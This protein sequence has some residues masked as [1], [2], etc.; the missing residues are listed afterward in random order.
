MFY[1][2][3]Y[4]ETDVFQ[5]HDLL[6]LFFGLTVAFLL[7]LSDDAYDT[8]PLIK[9]SCQILCGVILVSTGSG[10]A[11]FD[12]DWLNVILTI[13]WVVGMMNSINMSDNHH[14]IHF[15]YSYAG[16]YFTAFFGYQ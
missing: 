4:G 2:I 3:I 10:I 15:Y 5:N 1:A 12:Q 9:L 14:N 6:G 11:L 16:W 8:R 7:G 13:F